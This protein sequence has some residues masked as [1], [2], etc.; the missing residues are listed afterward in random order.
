MMSTR[1]IFDKKIQEKGF[2]FIAEISSNHLGQLDKLEKL[3]KGAKEA[4]ADAVKIQTFSADSLTHKSHTTEMYRIKEGPWKGL[5]YRELYENIEVPL[6]WTI[7]AKQIADKEKIPII[8]SPFS[9]RDVDF[10]IEN[11]YDMIKIASAELSHIKLLERAY[12]LDCDIIVSLGYYNEKSRKQ[13]E[14]LE[15]RYGKETYAAL[16]CVAKYPADAKDL[17]SRL[18]KIAKQ[19]SKYCGLSDH[20]LNTTMIDIGLEF[21]IKVIEKHVTLSRAEGGPDASFSL[22]MN[23]LK[24]HI[25]YLMEKVSGQ[26]RSQ[27]INDNGMTAERHEENFSRSLYACTNLR[28]GS[29]L[30]YD[31]VELFRPSIG[32]DGACLNQIIGRKIIRDKKEG[33]PVYWEELE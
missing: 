16:N 2:V 17:D 30:D 10:L 12:Y 28:A 31:D 22:E 19:M 1:S 23:E 4:G 14:V 8:S 15:E 13:I 9:V 24:T 21:G 20:S 3:I 7:I 11:G 18:F 33:E 26:K 25:D 27:R 29:I 5:T 32:I 6:E